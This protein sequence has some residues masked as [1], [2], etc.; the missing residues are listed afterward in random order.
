MLQAITAIK[1]LVKEKMLCDIVIIKA[2]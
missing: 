2:M 1:V